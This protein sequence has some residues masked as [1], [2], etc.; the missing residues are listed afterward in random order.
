M[1]ERKENISLRRD[2]AVSSQPSSR[3]KCVRKER[4][5]KFKE[6]HGRRKSV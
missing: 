1:L 5:H 3:G 6:G 4:E 2:T